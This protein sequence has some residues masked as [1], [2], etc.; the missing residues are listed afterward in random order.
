SEGLNVLLVERFAAGGQGGT[1]SRIENYLGFPAGISGDELTERALKQAKQFDVEM[2]FKRNVDEVHPLDDGHCVTL[3]GGD[4]LTARVL[5]LTTG[6]SWQ[7]LEFA[8][9][10]EMLGR[11]IVYGT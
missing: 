11:G 8:G 2:L 7:R 9:H 6:V 1:S 10:D 5:L 4:R 3:E